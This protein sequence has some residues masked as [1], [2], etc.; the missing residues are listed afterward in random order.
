MPRFYEAPPWRFIITTL[1]GETLTILDPLAMNR[2]ITYTL[3]DAAVATCDLPSD[4]PEVNIQTDATFFMQG[5]PFVSFQDKL[6]YAFRRE[7]T[8]TRWIVRFGG[9]VMQLNDELSTDAVTPVTRLTAFDPWKVLDQRP[10]LDDSGQLPPDNTGLVYAAA[11][12]WTPDAIALDL[13]ANAVTFANPIGST[14]SAGPAAAQLCFLDATGGH[15]DAFPVI[16]ADFNVLAGTSVGEAWRQLVDAAYLDIVLDPIY[17]PLLRPGITATVN[18]YNLAGSINNTAIF[19]FDMPGRSLTGLNRLSDGATMANIV[20]Y[21]AGQGG[22]PV[23]NPDTLVAG[24]VFD[25]ASLATYGPYWLQQSWPG[26]NDFPLVVGL[27][28]K[29]QM[30]QQ[31]YGVDTL[32]IDPASEWSPVPLTDYNLGDRVPVWANRTMRQPIGPSLNIDGTW[33]FMWRVGMIPI[34]IPDDSPETV[35]QLL[36][37][38]PGNPPIDAPIIPATQTAFG[39]AVTTSGPARRSTMSVLRPPFT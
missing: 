31:R 38:S 28:A 12:G 35:Q 24:P 23:V 29:A 16:D 13:L 21:Y 8:A 3:N 10:V 37:I 20:Q 34:S 9:L 17:D 30:L 5:E 11:D 18:L 39:A 15:I 6:L 7:D 33:D 14:G 36:L 27:A 2:T 4:N 25:P 1:E 22:L 19:S 32:T 26:Q